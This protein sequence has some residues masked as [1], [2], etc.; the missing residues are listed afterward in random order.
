[1]PAIQSATSRARRA[2][3]RY[4]DRGR[5]V[6]DCRQTPRVQPVTARGTISTQGLASPGRPC[7]S[8]AKAPAQDDE[9]GA[10]CGLATIAR[11]ASFAPD[12]RLASARGAC[13]RLSCRGASAPVVARSASPAPRLRI[14]RW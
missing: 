4:G 8:F 3:A 13:I 14:P 11:Q 6:V 10:A 12:D 1:M 2:A 5:R 7:R 9:V